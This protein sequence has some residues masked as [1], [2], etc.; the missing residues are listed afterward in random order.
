MIAGPTS[1]PVS[2]L[3]SGL[4]SGPLFSPLFSTA[5]AQEITGAASGQSRTDRET[6]SQTE[7]QTDRA[8]PETGP[9]TGLPTGPLPSGRAGTPTGPLP[10]DL[11]RVLS[12]EIAR[13]TAEIDEIAR[14]RRWQTDMLR[15]ARTNPAEAR[16]LRRPMQTCR[17]SVL[18][19]LC[20]RLGDLF[21]E[22]GE[23]GP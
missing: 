8:A 21:V 9:E 20:D 6:D 2:G 13:L 12:R 10:L 3:T 16:R 4:T 1:G 15:I 17:T 7:S 18:A 23:E 5:V 19:P 22:T 14:L 11:Q